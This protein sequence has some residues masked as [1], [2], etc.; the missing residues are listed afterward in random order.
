MFL[1]FQRKE[2]RKT[3]I[4]H[5]YVRRINNYIQSIIISKNLIKMY[6]WVVRKIR[7]EGMLK[8]KLKRRKFKF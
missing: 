6:Y 7:A 2:M 5:S 1:A 4:T 3:R 8:E